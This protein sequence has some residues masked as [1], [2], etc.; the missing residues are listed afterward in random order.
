MDNIVIITGGRDYS[1][2]DKIYATLDHFKPTMIIVGCAQGADYIT[3][4][5]ALEKEIPYKVYI[6]DWNK[7]GKGAGP[8]RNREMLES[9]PHATV[10]AFKGGRGTA[11]CV[12]TAK[13]LGLKVY[14][15][16]E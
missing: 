8:K 4:G 15:V 2:K 16:V 1:N 11:N 14:E 13:S 10:I 7:Y 3:I 6:A 5:Y 9:N 12:M